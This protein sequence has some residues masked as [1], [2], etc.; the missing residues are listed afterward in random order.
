MSQKVS[1]IVWL[2][3]SILPWS[4]ALAAPPAEPLDSKPVLLSTKGGKGRGWADVAELKKAAEAHN[5]QACFDYGDILVRGEGVKQDVVAGVEFLREAANAGIP[6]AAFRLGKI[7][8]DGELMPQDFAQAFNFYGTAATGGVAEA[9]YNLGV[10]YA[11]GRGTKQDYVEGLAWLIVAAK[12]GASPDGEQKTRAQLTKLKRNQQIAA[13]EKRAAEILQDPAS[14]AADAGPVG[15]RPALPKNS[16]APKRVDL[17]GTAAPKIN[18]APTQVNTPPP[19]PSLNFGSTL[20]RP[21]SSSSSSGSETKTS[22]DEEK[23]S[24]GKK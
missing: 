7:Y 14:A 8:D 10:L 12:N 11:T 21:P 18:V 2:A 19:S 23:N 24:T 20:P 16:E 6:N 9:Q 1:P 22:A 17:G 15:A 13:A 4:A 3:F 5:A